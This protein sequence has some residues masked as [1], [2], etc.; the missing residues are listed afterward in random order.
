MLSACLGS[1]SNNSLGGYYDD[2]EE[3][4]AD[5]TGIEKLAEALK[6]N[7]GLTSIKY[8]TCLRLALFGSC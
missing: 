7:K 2:E 3:F 8:A 6:V 1:L 5:S 4:Q